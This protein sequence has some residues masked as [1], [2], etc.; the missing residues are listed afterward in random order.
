[1]VKKNGDI[2]CKLA[3]LTIVRCECLG[4]CW[5]PIGHAGWRRG[6]EEDR[7]CILRAGVGELSM[8]RAFGGCLGAK[9]R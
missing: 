3:R 7:G 5:R 2:E 4:E 8:R 9:R 6:P 1:M